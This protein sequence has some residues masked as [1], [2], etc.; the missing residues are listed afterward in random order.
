VKIN[1]RKIASVVASTIMI[2]STVALAA[3]ANYPAPFVQSGNA[4]VA[5]VYGSNAVLDLVAVT[6][7]TSSL[8][9]QLARQTATAGS[10][11]GASAS[12]G[13]SVNLATSS[14]N[15]FF[16]S[17]L[18]SAK[19][20]LT[21]TELPSIL[22][23]GTVTDNAGT[24]YTYSQ[25]ITIGAR[26]I[27]YGTAS[28]NL[29][30]PALYVDGGT[31]TSAPVYTYKLTFN[32]NLNV[33]DSNVVGTDISI[34][35][36]GYTIGANS[37]V[38]GA[39]TDL[40]YLYGSGNVVNVNEGDSANVTIG[41]TSHTVKVVS[42][43]QTSGVNQV[44]ISVDGGSQ[45]RINEGAA[46]N[47]NGVQ[48]F[49]KTV[50][51]SASNRATATGS[52]VSLNLGTNVL[53]LAAN[54]N[55]FIGTDEIAVQNTKAT[56]SASAGKLSGITLDVAMPDATK[57]FIP[58]G[59]SFTDPV[60]GGLKV[61]FADTSPGMN[62][63]SSDMVTVDSDNSRN[64]RVSFDSALSGM[65]S[66]WTFSHDT[67]SDTSTGSPSL[68]LADTS[69]KA[70]HIV[71][72]DAVGQNE[73]AV[74]NSGDYG[75]IIKLTSVP[76]GSLQS[77]STIQFQDAITG[78][79]IFS[80]SGLTVGTSGN[81][82]TNVDGQPYWFFVTNSTDQSNVSITWG[83]SSS[84]NQVGSVTTIAPRIKLAN[85]EWMAILAN[86]TLTNGTTYSLPG[87]DTVATYE[88]GRQFLAGGTGGQGAVGLTNIFSFGNVAYN[89]SRVAIG[90][91][92]TSASLAGLQV[93]SSYVP[94]NSSSGPAILVQEEKKTTESGNSND[95]DV[96]VIP[97]TTVGT[98]T[99]TV[100]VGTPKM[101]NMSSGL[102]SW[103]SDSNKQTAQTRY[104]TFVTYSSNN[105]HM[106]GVSYPNQQMVA[107]VLFTSTGAVVTPGSSGSGNVKELGSVAVMDTEVS[108]VASKNL[109]VVG[110]S[111]VN[112]VAANLLGG[113][114]CGAD[115][116]TKSG[117]AAGSFLIQT[118]DRT[119]GN[120]ATLVAGYNAADTENAAKYLTTQSV[121]TSIGKK[122]V[123]T[124]S[125][126]ASLVTS[127]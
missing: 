76:T 53:K 1:F 99:I 13:D 68:A 79:P 15:L 49:A 51:Y 10:S 122:Y 9:G 103:T 115:F 45:Q 29:Q 108:S 28:G 117:V 23:D 36:N 110:G 48:V 111:C 74:I 124:S 25:A 56:F 5:V 104:G 2:G 83:T 101:T 47:I 77:T 95:G 87:Y 4:N 37:V 16:G 121:D 118:F 84:G 64:L 102:Q 66:G 71:E 30:D 44:Y 59:G 55:V 63:S 113:A 89:V 60:F 70:I 33:S 11:T 17:A 22:A 107:D 125:T 41:T 57:A 80:G 116:Q 31:S 19:T 92:N 86:V 39:S 85:G 24:A 65:A 88:S 62:S 112:S 7:I 127:S 12:G 8:Q 18:N 6:D 123:G 52:Y 82:T 27:S 98:T 69:N 97:A 78:T 94:F 26:N 32:K 91:T 58:V 14:Q 75:R 42:I 106:V 120:V 61:Q 96:I 119:G 109:I 114:L 72:G 100:G 3:A 34:L 20:S 38:T 46:A 21:K 81:V 54:Q 105:N 43:G 67:R 40:L 35:G 93:G 73:Y 126:T 90:T 50:F